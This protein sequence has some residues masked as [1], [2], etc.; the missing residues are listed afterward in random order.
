MLLCREPGVPHKGWR[1]QDAVDSRDENGLAY[2]EYEDCQFCGHERIRFVHLLEH[3][4]W[5]DT[6][7]VGCVCAEKLT[8]DYVNPELRERK[9]RSFARSRESRRAR[10]PDLNG[11]R[12]SQN[13]NRWI[14]YEGFH[15]ILIRWGKMVRLRIDGKLGE[16]F[17]PSERDAQLGAFDYIWRKQLRKDL[18]QPHTTARQPATVL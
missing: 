5:P 2:D 3:D 6:I 8:E 11:W 9:L 13:G 10:F 1:W 15:V 17:Y 16:R 4:E 14:S 7:R 12:I 18:Q